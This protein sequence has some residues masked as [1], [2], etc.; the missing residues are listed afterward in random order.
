MSQSIPGISTIRKHPAHRYAEDIVSGEIISCKRTK[1]ACQRYLDDLQQM[2]ERGWIFDYKYA[3]EMVDWFPKFLRHPHGNYAGKSFKLLPWEQFIIWNL[4]GF[5]LHEPGKKKTELRRRFKYV[6]VFIPK[7]NGKTTLGAGLLLNM[8]MSAEPKPELYCAATARDQARI[9]FSMCQDIVR[10]S[11]AVAPFIEVGEKV[12]S[13]PSTFA[14]LKPLASDSGTFEGI[15]VY[16]ALIDEGHVHKDSSVYNGLKAG[17]IARNEPIILYITTAGFDTT[18]PC[19]K[20]NDLLFDLLDGKIDDPSM[21]GVY[22]GIDEED[23][24]NDEAAWIKANP[25]ISHSVTLNRLR[26]EYNQAVNEGGT[27][28]TNFKTKHLNIWVG[29]E[30]VWI[31][32]DLVKNNMR[33]LD[34]T[35]LKQHECYGGLDLA[36]VRDLTAFTLLWIIDGIEHSKTWCW[37]PEE[38]ITELKSNNDRHPWIQWARDGIILTT[39]GNA[40]DYAFVRKFISDRASEFRI[41]SI[42]YDRHNFSQLG[43]ELTDDGHSLNPIGQGFIGL[44][45]AT[46]DLERKLYLNRCAIDTDPCMRWQFG[47]VV[48]DTDAAGNIKPTKKKSNNKIDGVVSLIIAKANY[49]FE[50]SQSNTTIPEDYSITSF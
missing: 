41:K 29:A 34:Y 37:V 48:I 36:S 17:T 46:K 44:S 6:H 14:T 10:S 28:I 43:Q 9:A 22:Y 7:K 35:M 38:R 11:P 47:N 39:P 12:I 49:N 21:F 24:W 26:E 42:G 16:G 19:K 45:E 31:P 1:Q 40:T 8:L 20:E 2:Q 4:Y 33:S 25:S 30:S 3:S 5:L 50:A 23:D 27:K 13:I 18:G 15:N 32:D